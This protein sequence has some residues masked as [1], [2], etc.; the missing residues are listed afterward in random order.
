MAVGPQL[1]SMTDKLLL[2]IICFAGD[3]S[4]SFRKPKRTSLVGS[5]GHEAALAEVATRGNYT[6]LQNQE[7]HLSPFG[8]GYCDGSSS[9]PDIYSCHYAGTKLLRQIGRVPARSP[10]NGSWS[11]VPSGCTVQ[12][13]GDWTVHYNRAHGRQS[14]HYRF[15]CSGEGPTPAPPVTSAPTPA[16]TQPPLPNVCVPP[17]VPTHARGD[18]EPWQCKKATVRGYWVLQFRIHQDKDMAYKVGYSNVTS[19]SRSVINFSDSAASI[20]QYKMTAFGEEW[21][22]SDA[23]DAYFDSFRSSSAGKME[24]TIQYFSTDRGNSVYQWFW[25]ITI[26]EIGTVTVRADTVQ[27]NA[28]PKCFPGK[29]KYDWGK[30]WARY[31]FCDKPSLPS[32]WG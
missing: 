10:I 25:K 26:E 20:M 11:H 1:R 18:T 30:N 8:A 29:A 13:G 32:P 24:E 12:S 27:C 9:N 21:V 28:K 14:G 17:N 16:P 6:G 5:L 23:F 31:Q 3:E 15:V 22:G 7:W 19:S 4:G 2:L